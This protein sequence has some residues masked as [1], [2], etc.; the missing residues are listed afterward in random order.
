MKTAKTYLSFLIAALVFTGYSAI[1]Q[2][3]TETTNVK[4]NNAA[5]MKTYLIERDIPNAGKL[6]P[7]E[8]KAISQKSCSL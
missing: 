7:E 3:T 2:T 4:T 5:K 6:T 8:L 1:A